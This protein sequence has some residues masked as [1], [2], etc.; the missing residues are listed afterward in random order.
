MEVGGLDVKE[1]P[2][3]G[4]KARAFNERITAGRLSGF[5]AGGEDLGERLLH[6]LEEAIARR[7][8]DHVERPA[9][10]A[11]DR[12]NDDQ[13]QFL[14]VNSEGFVDRAGDFDA[15]DAY[16]DAG[17]SARSCSREAP[18]PERPCFWRTGSTGSA[19]GH[20]RGRLH[21]L[22]LCRRQ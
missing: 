13:E 16:L 6:D 3:Q 10:D 20:G 9:G 4:A 7:Y 22:P 19:P 5:R 2:A 12:E 15:L 14:F 11:L 18:V 8:P 1:D 17:P 21:R